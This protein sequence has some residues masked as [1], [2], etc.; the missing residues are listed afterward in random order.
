MPTV[1]RH[2]KYRFFFFSMENSLIHIHVK[3]G[4]KYA[5]FWL[6]PVELSES[7]G[8][9]TKELKETRKLILKNLD[10]IKEKWYE[11]FSTRC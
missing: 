1:F 4:D 3:S 9:N 11:H 2:G 6:D 10:T 8:Y 5:K 7:I